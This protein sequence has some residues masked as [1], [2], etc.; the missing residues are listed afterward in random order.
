[1]VCKNE[2]L[3]I[4]CVEDLETDLQLLAVHYIHIAFY[5]PTY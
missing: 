3:L 1:M 4:T 5:L 2:C